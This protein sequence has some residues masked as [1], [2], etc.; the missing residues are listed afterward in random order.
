[1]QQF[2]IVLKNDKI[3]S[4]R[5]IALIILF[6]NLSVFTFFLFYDEYRTE[7]ASAIAVIFIY[8][9]M[10]RSYIKKNKQEHYFNEFMFFVLAFCWMGLQNYLLVLICILWGILFRLALQKLQFIFNIDVV[11]K[12]NFPK[13][14]FGWN[15][16][17][18]VML[19]DNMLTLDF[20]NNKILQAEIESA[21]NI[22][23]EEF[24]SFACTQ[25]ELSQTNI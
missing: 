11:K 9:L 23:E 13:K 1:M 3:K 18:N 14:E 6:L 10:R 5:F 25:I 21:L 7:A 16:F 4:Y 19:K 20:K 8:I 12:E 17:S 15:T 22:N 2:D 24:N